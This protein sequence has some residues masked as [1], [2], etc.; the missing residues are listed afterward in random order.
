MTSTAGSGPHVREVDDVLITAELAS[1][2]SRTPDYEAESRAL[3][4]LAQEIATHP[5]GVL[6]KCAELVMELCDADSAGISILEPGGTSGIFRWHAAAG[7]LAPNLHGTMPGE[8]SPCGTVMERNCVLL[9]NEAERFFPALRSVEPR[10]YENL[11]APWHVNGEAAGTLWAIKH[12]PEGRFD[13]EDARILQSLARFAAAAFQMTSALDETT[14]DRSALRESEERLRLIVENARDYAIFTMD[15]DGRVTDWRGGA[16]SIFGYA[17]DE[18]LGKSGDVLFTP[19]DVA[20]GEPD[21]ER[22]QAAKEGTAPNIR[23]HVCRD[24]SRVFIEGVCTA[25]LDS[26]GQ[27]TGFLKIGR[28]ATE[29]HAAERRQELLLA[30]LQHRVRNLLGMVRS[31]VRL[32][33]DL[34]DNVEDYVGHLVGRLNAMGRT[35]VMLTRA[36]GATVDLESLIWDELDKLVPDETKITVEGPDA[37]LSA[38]AAEAVTLAIHELATNSIKYGALGN[39]G[40]LAIRWFTTRREDGRWLELMW[41]EQCPQAIPEASRRGFGTELIE[42]RVPYELKGQGSVTMTPNGILAEIA[43]PMREGASILETGVTGSVK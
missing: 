21:K 36:A 17:R 42:N 33:A 8:A 34:Y 3:G 23:W 32:S 19:E 14:A 13:A 10:I 4:L 25:L 12:T 38:K 27:L 41:Q 30:E 31:M 35:Q 1:R 37:Q 28:D 40:R 24:G 15:L 26:E 39:A 18:I 9:F 7:A 5:R 16:E 22:A 29:R 6:Q 20:A 2:T 11:L 43:F